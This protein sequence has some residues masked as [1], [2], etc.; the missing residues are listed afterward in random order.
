MNVE[1][2]VAMRRA[3]RMFGKPASWKVSSQRRYP[4]RPG[5]KQDLSKVS[6]TTR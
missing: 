4:H 1:I 6:M 2:M 5:S 3:A